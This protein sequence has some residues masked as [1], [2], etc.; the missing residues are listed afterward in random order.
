MSS[1]LLVQDLAILGVFRSLCCEAN[2]GVQ[3][4]MS[5]DHSDSENN[6]LDSLIHGIETYHSGGEKSGK[7]KKE[8]EEA[9]HLI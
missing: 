7:R 8:N 4:N 2:Y 1:L 3:P 6:C 9:K 5:G